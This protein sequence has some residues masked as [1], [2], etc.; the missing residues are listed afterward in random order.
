MLV[1]LAFPPGIHRNGTDLEAT[2]R[3]HNASLVRWNQGAM[4]PVGGWTQRVAATFTTPARGARGWADNT[5]GRWLALGTA[6]KLYAVNLAGTV[7]DITPVG[8]VVGSGDATQNLGYGGGLYGVGTYGT[9]RPDT[10]AYED[11]TTWSL[12]TW[13]QNLLACSSKDRKIYEWSLNVANPAVAMVNAPTADFVLTS[14]ERFVFALGAGNDP[15]K[16]QWSDREN[17]TLWAPALTNEAGSITLNI[18]GKIMCGV[19]VRGQVL[20]LTDQTAHTAT[21]IGPPFVHSVEQVGDACGIISRRAVATTEDG[22]FWMGDGGFFRLLGG[23]VQ[24]IPCEVHDHV[25]QGL[26]T[27]QKSKTYSVSNT[28]FGEI[29]WHYPGD[30]DTECSNYVA[31]NYRENFWMIGKMSR[32]AGVDV[33]AF[34]NPIAVAPSGTIYNHET[35]AMMDGAEVFAESGPLSF[36]EVVATALQMFPDEKTRGEVEV[37]FKTRYYPNGAESSHGPYAMGLPTN[38]R[39]TGRQVAMRLDGVAE[40][41]WRVGVNQLKIQARGMR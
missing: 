12:D 16:V 26:T 18:P 11:A 25:F 35:G 31:Y 5:G 2:G 4:Q 28:K 15:R 36:G 34:R 9:P 8:L 19:K 1:P 13:G 17:N 3:W 29:W 38:L 39:F 24:E 41:P 40:T 10:G 33:G 32:T 27:A 23:S 21:Y 7:S 20:I 30:S 6:S 14:E 37:T 22:A